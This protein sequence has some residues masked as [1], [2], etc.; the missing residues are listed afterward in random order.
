MPTELG[1]VAIEPKVQPRRSALLE[2]A[3]RHPS[4]QAS[5]VEH[6]A[7]EHSGAADFVGLRRMEHAERSERILW[8]AAACNR[9][10]CATSMRRVCHAIAANGIRRWE[11]QRSPG[12]RK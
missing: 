9:N 2:E 6:V 8:H 5:H 1:P 4:G 3:N 11:A 12:F 7:D 10:A